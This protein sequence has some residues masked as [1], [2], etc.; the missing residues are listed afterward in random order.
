M[1]RAKGFTLIE[2]ITVLVILA[3][4]AGLSTMFVVI[5]ADGYRET[6]VRNRLMA[7]G[8]V[9]LEQMSRRIR[10]SVPNSVRVSAS[11]NCVE[12]LPSVAGAF[13][14]NDVADASNAAAFSSA[15]NTSTLSIQL[16]NAEYALIAPMAANE[17]YTN[18][19]PSARIG[20]AST[21]SNSVTFSAAHQ[22]LRN[23]ISHRIYLADQP[24][25]FCVSGGN[26]ELREDYG[27]DTATL[28]DSSPGGT[29][30][31]MASGVSTGGQAFTLTNSSNDRNTA[32]Q[33]DLIFSNGTTQIALNHTVAIRNVP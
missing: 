5:A 32:L 6:Q 29:S 31:L 24:L 12:L 28:D 15:V 26:L 13:Y 30:A 17:I 22:F 8:R 11:G 20:V 21:V 10:Q 27:L 16:G 4:V 14:E 1:T 7:R 18:A 9:V 23:S 19:I 2:L 25:R 3:V 33:M